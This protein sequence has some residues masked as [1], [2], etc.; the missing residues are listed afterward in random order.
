METYSSPA[1]M[2]EG[3]TQ[4]DVTVEREFF[5]P[6]RTT[7]TPEDGADVFARAVAGEFGPITPY[8]L[9]VLSKDQ[10]KA[11]ASVMR[12]QREGAGVQVN[13]ADEGDPPLTVWAATTLQGQIA[14]AGAV[15]LASIEPT[16]VFPW[17]TSVG[18]VDLTGAQ[19]VK[20]GLAVGAYVQATYAALGEVYGGIDVDAITTIADLN[21]WVWPSSETG[22]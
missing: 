6:Y 1:W 13:V 11:V 18:A 5:E 3:H 20:I 15:Q 10:L 16:R 9:S 12:A 21:A 7:V 22:S 14:I 2:N 17:V 4:I 8:V 19:V